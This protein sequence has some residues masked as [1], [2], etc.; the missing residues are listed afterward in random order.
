MAQGGSLFCDTK[1]AKKNISVEVIA[2]FLPKIILCEN[3]FFINLKE[4][5]L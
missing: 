2:I 3:I 1:E 4:I 5:N